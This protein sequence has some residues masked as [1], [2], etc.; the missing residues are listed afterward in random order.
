MA[1]FIGNLIARHTSAASYVMPRL[2]GRFEPQP[3]AATDTIPA[4]PGEQMPPLAEPSPAAAAGIPEGQQGHIAAPPAPQQ[5]KDEP[6]TAPV[7]NNTIAPPETLLSLFTPAAAAPPASTAAPA[8]QTPVAAPPVNN[9]RQHPA[10]RQQAGAE[11]YPGTMPA[12]GT[13][14]NHFEMHASAEGAATGTP[15]PPHAYTQTAGVRSLYFQV[16]PPGQPLTVAPLPNGNGDTGSP[17][18]LHHFSAG[19]QQQRTAP[20]SAAAQAPQQVIKV[21]IGRID[22]RAQTQPAAVKNGTANKAAMSLD[23]FLKKRSGGTS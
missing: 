3:G 21:S 6:L 16:G 7:A 13:V 19:R 9:G 2:R 5:P 12:G 8:A 17:Q 11:H 10:Q 22:V 20:F 18:W 14:N 4:W 23:D 15:S 1:N